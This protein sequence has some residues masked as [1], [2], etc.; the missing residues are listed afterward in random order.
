MVIKTIHE[1][2]TNLTSAY[3]IP[4]LP[5][6]IDI[7]TKA[8]LK[9]TKEA[10]RALGE[11]KGVALSMPNQ[12]ILISTLS[13]QEAKDSSAI[14]NIIT[15]H[16]ELYR[17]DV[18]TQHFTSAAAKEVHMYAL[19]LRNGFSQVKKTGL[20]TNN[21]IK[22]I[23]A[24]LEGNDAGFRSQCGTVLKNEQTGEIV[25]TPPQELKQIEAHMQNLERF[26]NENELCD[27]DSLVKTAIIHHQFESIHPF[28]DGNGRTG[29]ILNILYLVKQD[30]LD[31]PILYLSRYINQNKPEYYRL[32]QGVRTQGMWEEWIM[33]LLEG[34]RQTSYQTIRLIEEI[35]I[36]MLKY[37]QKMRTEAPK[38]YSQ[39]LLNNLFSH[40]YTKRDFVEKELSI[41]RN[42]ATKY[43]EELVSVG[44][45]TKLKIGKES[46]YLN[47]RLIELLYSAG[48]LS[49]G[50]TPLSP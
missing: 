39:D 2:S 4:D 3:Q 29:R 9:K 27:W 37:K 49:G 5:L 22:S 44:L 45:L 28:F 20:L 16:D 21:L 31:T 34:V 48:T 1:Q 17:S 18:Q 38:C 25:Y 13:L 41:H 12:T 8:V 46:F 23:Q 11:L 32:L 35:K 50:S 15:T 42:T 30:L 26:I 33:F 19:A 40:P 24:K 36:L 10:A 47:H 14:E 7:E 6:P 43:L